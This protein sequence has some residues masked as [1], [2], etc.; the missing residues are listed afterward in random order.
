MW[1]T[2]QLRIYGLNHVLKTPA[3]TRKALCIITP[4]QVF[5][6]TPSVSYLK[7]NEIPSTYKVLQN[8]MLVSLMTISCRDQHNYPLLQVCGCPLSDITSLCGPPKS[9]AMY[10]VKQS[11][12]KACQ[13]LG[14]KPVC[15]EKL[16]CAW[17]C[18][19]FTAPPSDFN[20]TSGGTLWH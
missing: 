7:Y 2:H 5:L 4:V 20:T 13:N 11:M 6:R 8:E 18:F 19:A 9:T 17:M 10:Q 14:A 15:T 3:K 12:N 1:P 16:S